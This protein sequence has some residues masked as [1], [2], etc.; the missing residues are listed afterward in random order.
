M[1][2]PLLDLKAQYEPIREEIHE[3]VSRVLESQ[4][5]I[6]GPEVEALERD[7]AAYCQCAH[8]VGVSSGTDALLISLMA[9]DTK[10]GDEVI[11]TPF[12]F[13]ATAGSIARLGARPVFADID[14]ATFNIDPAQI[15][16]VLTP[17][18]RAI[19]P[20]HLYGQ[21]ADMD[22]ILEIAQAR[23]L[24][25]IEDAAQAIGAEYQGRR[26]GSMGHFGCFSFFPSKNLGGFGDGGMVTTNSA[27]LADRLQ[28][29]RNHGYH[30]QY[31]NKVVGGNF[32]LD[33]L[34][35]AVLRV[36]L[37]RLDGWI[38]SR[39]RNAEIYRQLFRKAGLT[40]P[41]DPSVGLPVEAP[42][43]RHVYNQFV[44]RTR[45]RNRLMRRLKEAGISCEIHYP[46]P[47]HLQECFHHLGYSQGDFPAGEHA[48]AC[49]LALPIYPELK[50]E[51]LR[52]IVDSFDRPQDGSRSSHI[53]NAAHARSE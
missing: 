20:V 26:A 23:G 44:I 30:P 25:V 28:L 33:A 29:L 1:K 22:P 11:T 2:I 45:R 32:R 17:R 52:F 39:R 34:Q 6:L 8:G 41:E 16:R 31:Y 49:T 38:E 9:I 14:P 40:G 50:P 19:I 18:T 37:R 21:T 24:F 3:A 7:V 12:T 48:A 5:F 27:K 46:L 42:G 35:A 13:F 10:P 15:E 53:S 4:R 51:A 43:R 47:M 36:K